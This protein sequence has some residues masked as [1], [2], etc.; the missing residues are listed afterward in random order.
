M[1]KVHVVPTR[2]NNVEL[3]T[4]TAIYKTLQYPIKSLPKNQNINIALE[5]WCF[6]RVFILNTRTLWEPILF[7]QTCSLEPETV[8]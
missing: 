2:V 7:S 8:C 4:Q 6:V 3:F 5:R 1:L